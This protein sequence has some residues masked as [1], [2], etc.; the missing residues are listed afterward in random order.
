MTDRWTTILPLPDPR[1][2]DYGPDFA[3]HSYLS[4]S[5][6]D[7]APTVADLDEWRADIEDWINAHPD[8]G[9]GSLGGGDT[10]YAEL[11][12]TL[13]RRPLYKPGA[14]FT[15]AAVKALRTVIDG[16]DPTD[17]DSEHIYTVPPGHPIQ[18]AAGT[19][20]GILG[21]WAPNK[22]TFYVTSLGGAHNFGAN[23]CVC[24][25]SAAGK[26]T[27]PLALDHDAALAVA[28]HLGG[29]WTA[30]NVPWTDHP[31]IGPQVFRP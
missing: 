14:A 18:A 1:T 28:A 24:Q 2:G 29:D 6:R 30:T 19:D 16:A 26:A 11:G 5:Y 21:G 23:A 8:G 10:I 7:R 22:N 17:R 20:G 31:T 12:V 9:D 3:E 15:A 4:F 27:Q 13:L 25:S